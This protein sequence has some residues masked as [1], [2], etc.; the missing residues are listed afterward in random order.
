MITKYFS[1]VRMIAGAALVAVRN[2]GKG[3]R[4]IRM[5]SLYI[6]VFALTLLLGSCHTMLSLRS[7]YQRPALS[8]PIDSLFGQDKAKADTASDSIS[9]SDSLGLAALSWRELFTDP[10]LQQLIEEGLH[11]NADLITARLKTDEAVASLR[12]AH[13][14][15]LPSVTLS[16]QG[17]LSTYDWGAVQK[18]YNLSVGAQWEADLFSRITNRER[19]AKATVAEQDAYRQ[20]VE[21]QLVATI[22]NSYY[23][24]LKLDNQLAISDDNL[25]LMRETVRALKVKMDVGESNEAAV[26][27]A[28]AQALSVEHTMSTIRQ[29]I[30]TQ[31]NAI[32]T[33]LGRTPSTINRG[34]LT[35][36]VF[37][38]T[39]MA[40]VP[41]ALLDGRPDV[42]QA[43]QRLRQTFYNVNIVRAAFYP[44]LTL[45]GTLG[46]T[47]S[48]G[49]VVSNP[50]KW[51]ANAIGQ[52]TQPIFDRGQNRAN[53]RIAQLQHDEA[54]VA[55]RQSLVK[56]GSEVNDALTQWQS[57]R[58]RITTDHERTAQ[59]RRTVKATRQLMA[60][61][62]S[63][64]YLEVLTAEANLLQSQLTTL[65]DTYGM[66][67]GVVSLYQALGGGTR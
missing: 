41:A 16:P 15:S 23:N 31:E 3:W 65:D 25:K 60:H 67:Q 66:I 42:R 21:S 43:E 48:A 61:S 56:V 39:I 46:W 36:E 44:S 49:S 35:D 58:G 32:C 26:T 40:G 33:L 34:R 28:E 45:S 2:R 54:M 64:N 30:R 57:A 27:Q 19:Y 59:L 6:A 14:A 53:L 5:T 10:D 24:L 11:N 9:R 29:N 51:I 38:D 4:H 37:P 13:L 17:G 8:L 22:A 20:A 12:A 47:N 52:L 50:G 7:E 63:A 1:Q 18:T 62:D 55:W